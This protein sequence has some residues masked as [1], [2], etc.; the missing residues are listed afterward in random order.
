[1]KVILSYGSNVMIRGAILETNLSGMLIV[2]Q[3]YRMVSWGGFFISLSRSDKLSCPQRR[4]DPDI[5]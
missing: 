1:M 4:A 5:P 2:L 3:V